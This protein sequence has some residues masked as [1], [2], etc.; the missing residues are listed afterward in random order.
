MGFEYKE[1]KRG[2]KREKK[3]EERGKRL[4]FEFEEKKVREREREREREVTGKE[5]KEW[6]YFFY[7]FVAIV[8]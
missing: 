2:E 5:E 8:A 4:G 6:E 1:K 7:N 3:I